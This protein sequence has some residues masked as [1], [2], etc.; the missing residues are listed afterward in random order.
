MF[1]FTNQKQTKALERE[2]Q[3]LRRAVEELSILNDLALEIGASSDSQKIMNRIISRSLRAVQGQQGAITLVNEERQPSTET[4]VRTMETSSDQHPYHIDQQLV[5]WMHHHQKP[6]LVNNPQ[7]DT[8]FTGVPWE[9]SIQSVLCVPLMI[10]SRLVGV[11][12][13]YNKKE[14]RIFTKEDQRLLAI[15]AGQS[16]QVIENA[17]LYEEEKELLV[18]QEELRLANKI[19]TKLLPHESPT[20]AN[21]TIAG[22]SI[23]AR[24]VGGD[25]FDYIPIDEERIG[26]CVGDVSGKGL[27]ASLLMANLQATLQGQTLWSSSVRECIERANKMICRSVS[28]ETFITLFYGHL[29][30]QQHR[31]SYV[32]AGHNAPLLWRSA[33][34]TPTE[35]SSGGLILGV[36]PETSYAE[37]EITFEPEDLLVIYSDGVTEAMNNKEQQFDQQRLAACVEKHREA[38]PK[39]LIEHIVTAVHDHTGNAPQTDDI[40]LLVIRRNPL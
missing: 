24:K 16:A 13:V 6:L 1:Q 17:R 25:Y 3:R 20:L 33:S 7:E 27:P 39:E 4:L 35:L 21:Y 34:T 31:F 29:H 26:L 15:I 23:P 19:Q 5:G 14:D 11:L 36:L 38:S 18:M 9:A 37:K 8:R 40:T 30:L 12:T 2:N 10:R 22:K 32:N 28:P